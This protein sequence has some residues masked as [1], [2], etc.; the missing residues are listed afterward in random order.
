MKICIDAGH[1][2][3]HTNPGVAANYVESAKMWELHLLLV[4]ELKKYE[5]VE[6]ITTRQT[7]NEDMA[8]R[9]RGEKSKGC[10]LFISLHSNACD[11]QSVNRAV[12]IPSVRKTPQILANA[13]ADRL[14]EFW[15]IEL[16]SKQKSQI[17]FRPYSKDY[18]TYDYYGV[19]YGAADV[20][21]PG[22]IIEHSFHT[23]KAYCQW[24][25]KPGSM[26]KL[27]IADAEAIA[28]AY[29]LHKKAEPEK[30]GYQ[31]G[32]TYIIKPGDVYTNKKAVPTRLIGQKMTIKNVK[33]GAILLK[34]IS[35]WVVVPEFE[36]ETAPVKPTYK[37]GDKFVLQATDTYTNGKN[38]PARLVGTAH[39]ITKAM[40][41]A[42][43]LGD[44]CSWVNV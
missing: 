16:N 15:S 40:D 4:E 12:I 25:M 28:R 2:T 27:A 19:L 18:P 13:F 43:L 10:D 21:V 26:E 39:I 34:E 9:A 6:I 20:N 22:I 23:N 11:T 7:L 35:S 30:K 38:V 44:I 5:D 29:G 33:E 32:D 37:V 41:G 3:N 24:A 1:S 14:Q 42:V 36:I 8:N 17:Y 31:I